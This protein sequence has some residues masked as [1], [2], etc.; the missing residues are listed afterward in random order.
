[1]T[2]KTESFSGTKFPGWFF[3][4][5]GLAIAAWWLYLFSYP[6]HRQVFLPPGA[7]EVDLLA[8]WLPDLV[9]VCP[10]SL[11]AGLAFLCRSRWSLLLAWAVAGAV[12][13]AFLYCVAWSLL[14]QGGWTSVLF[15]APAASFSAV[16]ALDASASTITIFRRSSADSPLRHVMDTLL[17]MALFWSCFLLVGPLAIRFVEAR[18]GWPSM[19]FAGQLPIAL[20]LF[21][22]FSALGLKSGITMAMRGAGT[23]LPFAAPN[24]LV[25]AG[26]YA[27][28]RNPM[29]VAGLGQGIAVALWMGSWA[30]AAYVL[31]GGLVW[32]FLVRPAEEQDLAQLFGDDYSRY[33][34]QVRC[35][36]PRLRAYS[37]RA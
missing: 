7:S 22:L 11:A 27:F 2:L 25:V 21:L 19:A 6:A 33:C 10:V 14:R 32:H 23:P 29:V 1:M 24:R 17:Q 8:F 5:Q 13:Y 28:L 12:N 3:I 16:A 4:V 30:V 36:V 26:P 35:W 34:Q 31:V 9:I 37:P 18:L 20:I 15:M